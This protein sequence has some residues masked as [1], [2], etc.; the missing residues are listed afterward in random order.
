MNEEVCEYEVSNWNIFRIT[1]EEILLLSI[2]LYPRFWL[3][4]AGEGC[5]IF[6]FKCTFFWLTRQTEF[7]MTIT[8]YLIKKSEKRYITIFALQKTDNIG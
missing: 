7:Y 5:C 1:W 6:F 8:K 3:P 4:K 2:V